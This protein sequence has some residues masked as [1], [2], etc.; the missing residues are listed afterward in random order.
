MKAKSSK[1]TNMNKS[2]TPKFRETIPESSAYF[3]L[4]ESTGWNQTYEADIKELCTSISNS[5]YSLCAY[6]DEDELIGFGRIVSDG[7][8]YAFICDMII[9]PAYQNQ[10][11]GSTILKKLVQRCKEAN[12]RVLWLFAAANKSGFYE[13]HGFIARPLD[14]PGMQLSLNNSE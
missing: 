1:P 9:H 14:A 12:I 2:F 3:R 13:K 5:W 11:I 4:F 10:G 7:V 8:L 6:T